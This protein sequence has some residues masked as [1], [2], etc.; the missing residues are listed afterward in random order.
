MSERSLSRARR[1]ARGKKTSD[2]GDA[3]DSAPGFAASAEAHPGKA[4]S[5]VKATS[6]ANASA[7]N[8]AART[9]DKRERILRAA[10]KVFATNG[11]YAT[12]VSDVAKAAGVAD[13]TI[14]LYFRS[15]DDVLISL[16]EDRVEKLLAFLATE[17]P[18]LP[19]A[20]AKLRRIVELELGLLEGERDLA[21]VITVTLRQSTTLMRE[22]AQP[23]FNSY[24]DIIARVIAEGQAAGEFR[25]D[26]SPSLVARATF[27]ALDG[28]ALTWALGKAERGALT[29]A[30]SGV[31]DLLLRGLA[32]RKAGLEEEATTSRRGP[33]VRRLLTKP[34][35]S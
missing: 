25:T 27:G 4:A 31:A 28:I 24:L 2:G 20:A 5:K 23:R 21:H 11:F 14:Y 17:L 15:K 7:K 34:A 6:T 12:R 32:R 1:G 35:R 9:G 19:T 8:G 22:Y 18:K 13:G 33:K 3:G 26:A 10:V 29:R 16:F 30:A